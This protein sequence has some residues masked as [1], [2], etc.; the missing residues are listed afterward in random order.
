MLSCDSFSPFFF[1][2][3]GLFSY[4]PPLQTFAIILFA[5]GVLTLQPTSTKADKARGLAIHQIFQIAGLAISEPVQYMVVLKY[6]CLT[7]CWCF[8]YSCCWRISH[9]CQQ[10]FAFG[11]VD[12]CSKAVQQGMSRY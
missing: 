10:G 5:Q 3:I 8:P 12:A 7:D 2:T 9:D 6:L 4:H 11:Y 1:P